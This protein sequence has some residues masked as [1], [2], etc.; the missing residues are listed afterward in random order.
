[1]KKRS[2]TGSKPVKARPRKALEP[3]GRS[4]PKALSR[5]GAAPAREMEVARLTQERDEALD[6]QGAASTVLQVISSSTGDLQP[7]FTTILENAVR[8][9]DARFGNLWLREDQKFRIVATHGGSPEY[10][11][12]LLTEPLV[13]PHPQSTMAR[14]ARDREVVQIED[15]S[16]A[17]TY[18][19]RMRIAT[20]KIA[21]ARTLVGV[22]L[23]P[24]SGGA[25]AQ[26]QNDA[27]C[28]AGVDFSLTI[29]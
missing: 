16:N 13:A 3:K 18:G 20:V 25:T 5:R 8:S 2:R 28:P 11:Q 22:P 7:V 12:Y 19:M 17:P 21:K 4:A 14:V 29:G 23:R 15:I 1:M 6:Q 10:E 9:C 27:M 24:E 26:Q